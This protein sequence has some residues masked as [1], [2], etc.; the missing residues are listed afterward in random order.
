LHD[1]FGEGFTYGV[2]TL[3][4]G[5]QLKLGFQHRSYMFVAP[6]DTCRGLRARIGPKGSSRD[7]WG[8]TVV[9]LLYSALRSRPSFRERQMSTTPF[10]RGL[11]EQC[12]SSLRQCR[13]FPRC[14]CRR[15]SV[16]ESWRLIA[17]SA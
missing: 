10:E 2:P 13:D 1:V 4:F 8:Y 12:I 17:R 5:L 11:L 3:L 9:R 14:E 7:G 16:L 6:R 15:M